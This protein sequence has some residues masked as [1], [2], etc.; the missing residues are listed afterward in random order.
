MKKLI[1]FLLCI[2]LVLGGCALMA[3]V[4][5]LSGE[6]LVVALAFPAEDYEDMTQEQKAAYIGACLE[7][8]VMNGGLCQFFANCP[9][10]AD[11]VPA[12]LAELGAGEHLALYE[13][14]LADTG[15]DPLDPMFRT[16]DLEE[17]SRLYDLYPWEEFDEPY[18]ELTPMAELL[19]DYVAAHPEAFE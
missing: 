9:D 4:S 19:E 16:E 18:C 8:E 14:F 11:D 1:A 10:C 5:T 7:L 12:A 15:I 13:A 17:F 2:C 6:E 3:D